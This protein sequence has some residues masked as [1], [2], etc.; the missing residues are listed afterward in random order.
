MKPGFRG[1]SR[2]HRVGR[3]R[4]NGQHFSQKLEIITIVKDYRRHVRQTCTK[5]QNFW[6]SFEN[7]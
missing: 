6:E 7:V 1:I 4:F 2:V 3:G 5:Y